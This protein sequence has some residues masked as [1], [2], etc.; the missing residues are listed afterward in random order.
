MENTILEK[1][2]TSC[3]NQL[4]DFTEEKNISKLDTEKT[5]KIY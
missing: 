1:Q 4:R 3:K 2:L 5:A